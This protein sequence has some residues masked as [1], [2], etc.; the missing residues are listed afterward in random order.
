MDIVAGQL[1]RRRADPGD[2]AD[3]NEIADFGDVAVPMWLYSP[4]NG[5]E[6][7]RRQRFYLWGH[8]HPLYTRRLRN[9]YDQA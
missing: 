2:P 4:I 1:T 5:G 7:G 9:A 8:S 3:G 6:P